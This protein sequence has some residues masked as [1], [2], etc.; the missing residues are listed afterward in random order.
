MIE[1]KWLPVSVR[2]IIGA[3]E[4]EAGNTDTDPRWIAASALRQMQDWQARTLMC[5]IDVR[6]ESIPMRPKPT[7]AELEEILASVDDRK[8]DI[9]PDGSIAVVP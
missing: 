2:E 6:P 1:V 5:N 8:I 4:R 7:I 9:Q 3:L